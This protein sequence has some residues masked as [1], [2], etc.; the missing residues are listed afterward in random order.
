ME[1]TTALSGIV[2]TGTSAKAVAFMYDGRVEP[3]TNKRHSRARG[4]NMALGRRWQAGTGRLAM[5]Q[6]QV[7]SISHRKT[8][9]HLIACAHR[10]DVRK[11][12]AI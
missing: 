2:C 1:C 12:T 7:P 10:S 9:A 4:D 6:R 3:S 11:K 8:F 5:G